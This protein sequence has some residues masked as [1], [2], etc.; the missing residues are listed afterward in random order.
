[1]KSLQV[2]CL[3]ICISFMFIVSC[4]K[5]K[6]DKSKVSYG[7]GMQFANDFKNRGMDLDMKAF[8]LAVEDVLNGKKNRLTD[9]EIRNAFQN[10]SAEMMKK[11][12]VKSDEN[13]KIGEAYLQKNKTKPG[14]KV[15]AS[16][17]QYKVIK[18]GAGLTPRATDIVKVHY[19]GN[20]IDGTEFDSSYKRNQPVEFPVNKVIPGWTEALQLMKVGSTYELTIPSNLAYGENGHQSVPGNAVLIFK[21]ELLDVKQQ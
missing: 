9:E 14:V 4:G 8:N 5:L 3:L 1:M 16:G 6:S 12:K 21:V 11:N 13:S 15:T 2:S 20:L 17:L 19:A 7:I 10:I 18:E